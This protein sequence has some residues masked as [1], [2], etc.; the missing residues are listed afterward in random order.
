VAHHAGRHRSYRF[1]VTTDPAPFLSTVVAASATLAAIIGGLLVARFVG[2]DSDQRTSRKI[3]QDAEERLAAARQRADTARRAV[4]S[5]DAGRFFGSS[6]VLEAIEHGVTLADDLMRRED[7]PHAEEDLQPLAGQV[8]E[9]FR[10]AHDVLP[11]LVTHSDADWDDF[12]RSEPGLPPIE[13]PQAWE[14]VYESIVT[15]LAEAEAARRRA[16][17]RNRPFGS[18]PDYSLIAESPSQRRMMRALAQVSTTDLRA[19]ADHRRDEL[20]ASHERALQQV[21]DYEGE[22]RR[23]RVAYAEIVQPDARLWW[24]IGIVMFFT[25]AGVALPLGVMSYGPKDLASVNWIF[26]PF[27]VGLAL[28]I[29]YIVVYLLQLTRRKPQ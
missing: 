13:W 26:W 9:E 20:V 25:L 1:R 27:A 10:A 2:L 28:L 19:T 15:K 8:A 5:W 21:E 12:Y 23:L 3:L 17:S 24:G 14:H 4:V 22:L 18:L 6:Q 11:G 7:W 16:A 29:G